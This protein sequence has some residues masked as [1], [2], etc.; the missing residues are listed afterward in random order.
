MKHQFLNHAFR[1]NKTID[2]SV[3]VILKDEKLYRKQILRLKFLFSI[4]DF[5]I[6]IVNRTRI[7]EFSSKFRM[8]YDFYIPSNCVNPIEPVA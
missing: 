6:A 7:D 4:H 5:L 1:F 8:P 2:T 3:R